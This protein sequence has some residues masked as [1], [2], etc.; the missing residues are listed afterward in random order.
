MRLNR[1]RGRFAFGFAPGFRFVARRL[2]ATAAQG[3]L[4]RR[5]HADRPGRMC[6]HA[7]ARGP[8]TKAPRSRSPGLS[9]FWRAATCA[10]RTDMRDDMS[11][12]IVEQPR[13]EVRARLGD[14]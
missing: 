14:L 10:G 3:A 1:I 8:P 9:C 11:K 13:R 2:C 5:T 7:P 6:I 4:A 12:V